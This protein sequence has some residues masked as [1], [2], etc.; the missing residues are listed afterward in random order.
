MFAFAPPRARRRPGLTPMID[1]VLLL[2]VFFM[3]ASQ[4]GR[5][6]AVSLSGGS[7]GAGA[8]Y[9]GPPRLITIYPDQITL[10]GVESD[11]AILPEALAPLTQAPD[12]PIILRARAGTDLQ[13]LTQV[14]EALTAAGFDRLVLVE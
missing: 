4:F 14:V 7:A 12:D 3:L 8:E 6:G 10:N 5:E 11:L 13:R 2:R 1:V 9:S